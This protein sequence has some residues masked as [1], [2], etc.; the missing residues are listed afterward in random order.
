MRPSILLFA[1]LSVASAQASWFSNES[2]DYNDWSKSELLKWLED[3]NVDVPSQAH[4]KNELQ[5]LV[6]SNW[7][8]ASAWTYD[9]YA[10][11][12]RA[13]AD[14]RDTAFDKWDESRLREFLLEQGVVAP[15]GPRE[16][17]VLLAKQ[18]YRAYTDAASSFSSVASASASSA[19]Y[20]DATYQ[21]SK[22][23][24]SIAAQA[25]NS[26]NA[27][28]DDTKDYI[29][30]TWDDNQLRSYLEEN[31]Y[32]K[33]KPQK[34]REEMLAMMKNAYAEITGSAWGAWSTSYMH[35]W[36]V[37]HNII[38][39]D[40]EK[41]R[42]SLVDHMKNYYY[43]IHDTAYSSW[44][45]SQLKNWLVEHD[46]I[47]GD[48]QIKRD[49][50]MKMIEDN[51]SHAKT[52]VWSAWSDNQI[53]DWLIQHGYIRS[54][55]QMKRDELVAMIDKKYKDANTRTAEYLTWPDARLRAYLRERGVDESA[56]PGARPGLLQEVRIKWVQTNHHAENLY[57]RVSEIIN[58]AV[59]SAEQKL[60]RLVEVL[61]GYSSDK[62]TAAKTYAEEGRRTANAKYEEGRIYGEK[63]VDEAR[64]YV[65]EKVKKSGEAIKGEL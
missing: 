11:A 23:L 65:G 50:M 55:V 64:D 53:R 57:M 22:S 12:Q 18:K 62:Y 49:K 59:D 43:D 36:L 51:Y 34:S 28:M 46:I 44:T 19:V 37:S 13:F 17:L 35:N 61:T 15:S 14:L 38:K 4:T 40:Y 3:H 8:T 2:P 45:D 60:A 58:S 5:E 6:K 25:T 47:K 9:Q 54:D 21:A 48:A 20:G 31:D 16:Q 42:G 29:Y 32:I 63:K 52:T 7:N 1:A 56:L 30:S 24:S 27:V 41:N 39:S 33:T 26:A 10:D